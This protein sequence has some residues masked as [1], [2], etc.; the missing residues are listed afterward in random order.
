[1]L[2]H[3]AKFDLPA[4]IAALDTEVGYIGVMG[5]RRTHAD[6][7]ARL[8]A[9]G[10]DDVGVA[11]LHAPIG[12]DLGARTPEE[13]AVSI[14]AEII[15]VRTGRTEIRPLTDSERPIHEAPVAVM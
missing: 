15:S 12:L 8:R 3:D 11:R 10:V 1:V 5:S 4:I 6:R 14:C 7:L 9:A 2:T 13:T